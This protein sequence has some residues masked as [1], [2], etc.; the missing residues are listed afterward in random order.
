MYDAMHTFGHINGSAYGG[1]YG[2]A[3]DP[4]KAQR[5]CEEARA[6][7]AAIEAKRGSK[8]KGDN[9]RIRNLRAQVAK[10]CTWSQR[11]NEMSAAQASAFDAELTGVD[12]VLADLLAQTSIETPVSAYAIPGMSYN[13]GST[14]G[15]DNTALIVGGVALVAVLGGAFLLL[16]PRR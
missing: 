9:R 15:G 13:V 7:L 4:T 3:K 14:G 2:L 8:S 11:I 5:K 6:K 10:L 12:Q 1:V 16:K